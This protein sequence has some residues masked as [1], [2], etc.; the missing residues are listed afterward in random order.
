M[1]FHV[2]CPGGARTRAETG[3]C[4]VR[5]NVAWVMVT[6]G[7][8]LLWT[9][10]QTRVKT[11][12]S[13]NFVCGRKYFSI[14]FA[15]TCLI[16]LEVWLQYQG[17]LSIKIK[18][19]NKPFEISPCFV[20]YVLRALV[21]GRL[22][23][24]DQFNCNSMYVLSRQLKAKRINGKSRIKIN[25]TEFAHLHVPHIELPLQCIQEVSSW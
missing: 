15:C 12:P 9:N 24:F 7:P 13:R 16:P 20:I 14:W 10:R 23:C 22:S 25:V 18:L 5:S 19:Q 11:F 1:G 6:W 4:T 21:M 3:A 17:Q 2:L 8:L